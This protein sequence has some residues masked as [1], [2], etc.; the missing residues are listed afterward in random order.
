MRYFCSMRIRARLLAGLTLALTAVAFSTP[1]AF[2]AVAFSRCPTHPDFE[3]GVVTV[4]LDRSGAIPGTVGLH[5]ERQLGTGARST[6]WIGLAGGP[7]QSSAALAETAWKDLATPVAGADQVV[8]FDQRGT[9]QSGVIDCTKA[10][11]SAHSD[12][13]GTAACGRSL[14]DA[15]AF[16]TTADSVADIEAV[17][18]AVGADR[19]MLVGVSYGTYVAERYARAFPGRVAGLVLDST[20][21]LTG[22]TQFNQPT[23]GAISRIL[24]QLCSGGACP[25]SPNPAADLS[26]VA[27]RMEHSPQGGLFITRSGRRV[28]ERIGDASTLFSVLLA[29]DFS[30]QARAFFPGAIAAA[31][32][33]DWAPL[34]R[35]AELSSQ[36][37]GGST[38]GVG[39]GGLPRSTADEQAESQGLYLAT[40]CAEAPLSWTPSS[41]PASREA[42]LRSTVLGLHAAAFAPFPLTTAV[43]TS[44]G[45]R[46]LSWPATPVVAPVPD[47]APLTVPALVLSGST[48]LRTPQ[49]GAVAEHD[50]IAGST[51]VRVPGVGHFTLGN[52]TSGC[53]MTAYTRFLTGVTPGDPC[54]VAKDPTPLT[55][56]RPPLRL[57]ELKPLAANGTAGRIVRAATQTLRDAFA[58]AALITP[59][60]GA[61][62]IGGLRGGRVSGVAVRNGVQMTLTDAVYLPG[63]RV[64]GVVTLTADGGHGT[65]SVAGGSKA[66]T[67]MIRLA[68]P[69]LSGTVGGRPVRLR[70][71]ASAS[72]LL[73]SH[74]APVLGAPPSVRL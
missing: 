52:D 32:R 45:A 73:R 10:F 43:E 47:T 63:L 7:G 31:K 46:C 64:S 44:T 18:V 17:R 51:L 14:G 54:A 3:C 6:V 9:G 36:S 21:P 38:V 35:L 61:V 57:S 24:T 8:V 42:L 58:S 33:G 62:R 69:R 11:A 50:Q 41:A 34:V 22:E 15:R 65:L 29:G 19:V 4:P 16:Y 37:A 5:V 48:D 49:S 66:T 74:R 56:P 53:A 30:P 27:R 68:G 60:R 28:S 13:G 71:T 23:Y 2:G 59:V 25:A 39:L 67:G 12:A 70:A 20:V 26:L 1:A 55:R 72:R 40:I